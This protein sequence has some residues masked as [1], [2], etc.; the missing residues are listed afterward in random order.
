MV[1]T[2]KITLAPVS[3]VAATELVDTAYG[4]DGT[5]FAGVTPWHLWS[6]LSG[7]KPQEPNIPNAPFLGVHLGRIQP[8]VLACP[9]LLHTLLEPDAISMLGLSPGMGLI[10]MKPVGSILDEAF[11][12]LWGGLST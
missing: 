1:S 3:D 11:C 7:V 5:C 8:P 2:G 10:V 4:L 12:G 9:G 6:L